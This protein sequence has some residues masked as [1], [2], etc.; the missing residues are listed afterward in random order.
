MLSSPRVVCH[1]N[2]CLAVIAIESTQQAKN[3]IGCGPVQI[4]GGFVANQ[5]IGIRHQRPG[6]R[7]TLLLTT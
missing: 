4:T 5:K 6:N 7:N 3:L 2:D 1:H